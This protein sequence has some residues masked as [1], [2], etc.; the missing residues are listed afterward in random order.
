MNV[1]EVPNPVNPRFL[2]ANMASLSTV[3]IADEP[4]TASRIADPGS[5]VSAEVRSNP[6][7]SNGNSDDNDSIRGPFTMLVLGFGLVGVGVFRRKLAFK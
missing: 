3:G 1:T 2:A 6:V 4:F 5:D 7:D